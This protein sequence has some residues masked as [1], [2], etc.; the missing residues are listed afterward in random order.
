[1]STITELSPAPAAVVQ[2]TTGAKT[3]RLVRRYGPKL[4]CYLILIPLAVIFLFPFYL[5]VRNALM[6]QP[7]IT[8]PVWQWWPAT[9]QWHNFRVLFDDAPMGHGLKVSAIL[10]V[11]NLIFQTLFASMAGYAL[12]RIPTPGRS[13]AFGIVLSTLMVPP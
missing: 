6:T 11:V 13:I 12:A 9:P 7:E 3:M 5:I 4:L 1:M 8:G 2:P 10:A